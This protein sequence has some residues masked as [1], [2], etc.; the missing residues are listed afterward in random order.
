MPELPE[1]QTTVS[2]IQ[3][4][5]TG[6]KIIDIWTNYNS[7]YFKG[8]NNIK[9]PVFFDYF[10]KNVIN[11]KIQKAERRGKNIL[12]HLNNQHT[13][14]IHMKM[15]GHVMYGEYIKTSDKKD[16]WKA[17]HPGPLRDDSFNSRI[18]F[19]LTLSNKKH[20]VLSDMRRF[21]KVTIIHTP[22]LLESSH[23]NELGLEPL[24]KN[25]TE[26]I[27]LEKVLLKP[28]SPIKQV[29]MDQSLIVGIGNIYSDEILWS[30]SV[31]PNSKSK[32]I[33]RDKISL[34]YKNMKKLLQKGIDF[35]GDSMSDYRNIHGEKGSFQ[36]EHNVYK[37]KGQKCKKSG[38]VG[39]IE[40]KI[41]GGR[42]AHFCPTHQKLY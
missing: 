6:L 18:R 36:N 23:V 22:S 2:G 32:N 14:L 17:V 11:S 27:F 33:P 3:K 7:P 40:R 41:I 15:T 30:S 26:K 29:L 38:C 19:V 39:V 21:A 20:L 16:P 28:K 35:G 34:M 9:D 42:S 24:D 13:I 25:F 4:H 37:R 5:V 10:K 12:I 31:H 8:K 1:V